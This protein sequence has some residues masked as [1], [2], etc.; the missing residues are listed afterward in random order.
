M[1]ADGLKPNPAKIRAVQ[2]FPAP[3]NV[4]G[5]KAF[6]GLCNYCRRFINGFA[7]IASPLNKLTSKNIKFDWTPE[8]QTSFECLNS[9]LVSAPVLAYPNFV[10][11]WTEI[12]DSY[13]SQCF[14][15]ANVYPGP[16]RPSSTVG[17]AHPAF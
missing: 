8:C 14:K 7:Q 11:I 10:L 15:V 3:T 12:H 17:T 1:S 5:V 4:T 13:R 9:A 2:E 6:L 16:H